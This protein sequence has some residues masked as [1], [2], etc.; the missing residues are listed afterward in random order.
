MISSDVDKKQ[1]EQDVAREEMSSLG[2]HAES[3][4]CFFGRSFQGR[5]GFSLCIML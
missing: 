2:S 4:I 1:M 3:R 5:T